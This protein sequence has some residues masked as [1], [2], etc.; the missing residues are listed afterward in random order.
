MASLDGPH[1]LSSKL[2][3]RLPVRLARELRIEAGDL[4]YWRLSDDVPGV[5]QLVPAEIV[6]RRYS[7]GERLDALDKVSIG[8][9]CGVLLFVGAM[10]N[11]REVF[12]QVSRGDI[13]SKGFDLNGSWVPWYNLHKLFAGL[14][15]AHQYCGNEEAMT[16]AT[17][18]ADFSIATTKNLT[19]EQ[20]QALKTICA[21]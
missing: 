12:A 20:W 9:M 18:L 14:I 19:P 21:S 1:P 13:R 7:A 15:D 3:L 8:L 17:Q 16:V 6:E 2:Q 5:L 11:G 10:P 4:L